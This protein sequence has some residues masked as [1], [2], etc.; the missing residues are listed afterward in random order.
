MG[1]VIAFVFEKVYLALLVSGIFF[2]LTVCGG[3]V[4]GFGP[5]GATV[6]S[7]VAAHGDD[8]RSYTWSEAWNL[9]RKNFKR[10]NLVFYSLFLLEAGLFY[11][12]YLI[13][14]FPPSIVTVT[15]TLVQLFLML[16]I[17]L[18]YQIYLKLQVYFDMSYLI[19]LKLSFLG[20]FVSILTLIKL[21]LGAVVVVWIVSYLPAVGFFLLVG[22]WHF[23]MYDTL[24]P[25]YKGLHDKIR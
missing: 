19:S 12:L 4:G 15:V 24:E 3:I 1:K 5:A 22:T 7:L 18:T 17:F 13:L 6:M 2:L 11:G 21:F 10:S 23:Y 14:Q 16:L 20:L 9:F 25:V 8:Y